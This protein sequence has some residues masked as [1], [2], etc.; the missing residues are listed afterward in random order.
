MLIASKFA[1]PNAPVELPNGDGTFT[2]YYFRTLPGAPLNGEHVAEIENAK[3]IERLLGIPEGYHISVAGEAAKA[4]AAIA[5]SQMRSQPPV[6][7]VPQPVA[8]PTPETPAGAPP[9]APTGTVP[10]PEATPELVETRAA[11]DA[12]LA[13][14]LKD[15]KVALPTASAL[16]VREAIVIEEGRPEQDQRPTFLRALNAQ[17]QTL[18]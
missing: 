2:T 12:L 6:A 4:Q 7:S 13:L 15:F 9:A 1:R 11:A 18:S 17:L 8:P 14:P 16:V 5:A 10:A 3:H